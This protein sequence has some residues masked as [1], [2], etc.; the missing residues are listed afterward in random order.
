MAR[1]LRGTHQPI[2]EVQQQ[3]RCAGWPASRQRPPGDPATLSTHLYAAR[4]ACSPSSSRT[5]RTWAARLT[6]MIETPLARLSRSPHTMRLQA[7]PQSSPLAMRLRHKSYP[8]SARSSFTRVCGAEPANK[9]TMSMSSRRPT[10]ET[11]H[12]L[13]LVSKTAPPFWRLRVPRGVPVLLLL[14]HRRSGQARLPRPLQSPLPR[15]WDLC[16]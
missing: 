1:R 13:R 3:P 5:P 2:G 8:S 7:F 14:L 9:P 11:H 10:S 12:S 4:I 16:C 6:F 15:G